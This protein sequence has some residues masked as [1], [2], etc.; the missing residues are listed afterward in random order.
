MNLVRPRP[1]NQLAWVGTVPVDPDAPTKHRYA[2]WFDELPTQPLPRVAE[3]DE[4]PPIR[5]FAPVTREL[6]DDVLAGLARL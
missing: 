4:R 3:V 5:G 1:G 6:L 2:A